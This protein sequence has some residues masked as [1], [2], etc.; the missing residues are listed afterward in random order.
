MTVSLIRAIGAA[1][2]GFLALQASLASACEPRFAQSAQSVTATVTDVGERPTARADTQIVLRNDGGSDC[3]AFL[4]VSRLNST[5][6][7][8]TRSFQLSSNGLPIDILPTEV[9]A[10]SSTSDLFV[11]AIPSGGGLNRSVP[12]SVV[13]PAQWGVSSGITTET[14]L[15]QLLDESGQ[16][17]DDLVLTVNLDVLPSVMLRIVG[18]TG[19]ERIARVD[20]GPLDPRRINRSAPFGVRV[21]STSPYTVTFASQNAGS[22]VQDIARDRIPYELRAS[23]REVDL[24]GGAP[25][26]FGP[27]TDGLGIHHPLEI[28]VPPFVAQAGSYSDRVTITVTAG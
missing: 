12:I 4:R 9:S 27:K 16:I 15:V 26:A 23:G 8:P 11:A 24:S 21:W 20:L 2:V 22:L 18:A 17:L 28:S 19:S 6:P 25:G 3:A 14:L 10:A 5:T 1:A 13:F 7:D